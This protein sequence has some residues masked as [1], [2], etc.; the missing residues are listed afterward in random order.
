[1]PKRST[2][3]A[4]VLL[5]AYTAASSAQDVK[6]GLYEITISGLPQKQSMCITPEMA[7]DMKNLQQKPDPKSDCKTTG[8]TGA[9]D[10]RSFQVKCTKPM[11]Y[12]AQVSIAKQGAD[13]FTMKQDYTMDHAGKP[14]KGSMTMTYK[15][16]G[17]C[18]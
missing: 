3:I 11:K 2:L 1:M 15:R 13:G 14:Q 7:K 4:A 17:D 6:P 10:T 8:D 12:E 16:V 9:G 5:L 18:K